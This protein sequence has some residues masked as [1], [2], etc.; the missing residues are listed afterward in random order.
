[1]VFQTQQLIYKW[2]TTC[3]RLLRVV[4]HWGSIVVQFVVGWTQLFPIFFRTRQKRRLRRFACPASAR[5]FGPRWTLNLQ[6]VTA[7]S[8]ERNRGQMYLNSRNL[9]QELATSVCNVCDLCGRDSLTSISFRYGGR[10]CVCGAYVGPYA[11]LSFKNGHW[12]LIPDLYVATCFR[13]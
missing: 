1:M 7:R 5:V 11:R 2:V 3:C 12:P 6:R 4:V 10:R 9:M 8:N 13:D